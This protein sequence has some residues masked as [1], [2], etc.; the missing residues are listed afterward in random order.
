MTNGRP[1]KIIFISIQST[2]FWYSS[3]SILTIQSMMLL[4]Y[5]VKFKTSGSRCC[6]ILKGSY[7]FQIVVMRGIIILKIDWKIH[8]IFGTLEFPRHLVNIGCQGFGL[9][10]K[11][12]HPVKLILD[13]YFFFFYNFVYV[14]NTLL[15]ALFF[16]HL[17]YY[18]YKPL[19]KINL[20]DQS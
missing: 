13:L 7:L 9:V 18:L 14:K 5:F 3:F 17:I 8:E 6:S 4:N 20:M 2:R 16:F 10:F 11:G 1:N 15:L 12:L 19:I